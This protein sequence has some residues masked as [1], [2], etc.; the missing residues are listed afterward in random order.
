MKAPLAALA[1]I[2][3]AGLAQ[4]KITTRNVTYPAGNVT[5]KGFLAIPEGKG[6]HPGVLVVHEFWG[7]N[8]YARDRAQMLAKLGYVAL[9]VDMYGDGK[10][11]DH[12]KDAIG[13]MN[14]VL[15]DMPQEKQRFLDA[16]KF[17]QSQPEVDASQ[18]AA[19]G[20][21]FGGGVVL[22]MAAD[23]VPG[24]SPWRA[25]MGRLAPNL[26]PE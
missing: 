12:P 3:A 15:A 2:L 9:A 4:A 1:L 13:F 24:F 7:M 23:D 22:Q 11:A 26:P 10:V 20:Y 19:I 17:L 6:K 8:S 5:A 14:A 21:C 25:S 18:I 16:M